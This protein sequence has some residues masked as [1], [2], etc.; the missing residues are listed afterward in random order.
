M[1]IIKLVNGEIR[2]GYDFDELSPELQTKAINDHIQF[3]IETMNDDSPYW[4]CV[5]EMDKMK[6]PWFLGAKIYEEYKESIIET[7][8]LNYLFDNEGE[9]LPLTTYT[10]KNNEIL[11]YTFGKDNIECTVDVKPV[12]VTELIN[13]LKELVEKTSPYIHKLGV[14]KGFSEL[15]ALENAKKVIKKA[16]NE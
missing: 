11:K 14:K 13:A 8:K 15:L 4:H 16:M 1:K 12:L 6:T 3:E 7:I 2:N 5:E 10:G 9:I